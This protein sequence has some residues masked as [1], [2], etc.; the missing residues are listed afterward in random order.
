MFFVTSA[1][2]IV[3]IEFYPFC[4]YS[5]FKNHKNPV[6]VT[7]FLKKKSKRGKFIILSTHVETGSCK[8]KIAR[9]LACSCSILLDIA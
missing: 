8:K 3:L 4:F 2:I 5:L 9:N 1:F 6:C 7:V